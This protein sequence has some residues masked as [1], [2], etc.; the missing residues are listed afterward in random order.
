MKDNRQDIQYF[1]F[2]QYLADGFRVTLEIILPTVI[3]SQFGKMD[4][5][6]MMSTGALCVSI[7]D[8]PGPVEHKQN[9]MLYC[10]L[11]IFLMTLVTGLINTNVLLLGLLVALSSFFFT[12][13][14]VF[15]NR[16]ASLGTA[17]L[18]VMVLRMDK[19]VSPETVLFDSLLVMAGGFWYLLFALLFFKIQPYRPAQRLLGNCLHETARFLRIKAALYDINSNITDEYRKLVT[20]QVVV[21]EKQDEL[22]ELLF[23]NRQLIKEPTDTG[24]LLLVTFA[25]V[26]DLYE[27]IMATWYDYTLLRQKFASTGILREVSEI[28]KNLADETDRIALA[29]QSNSYYKKQYHLLPVLDALKVKIDALEDSNNSNLVLKK[30]LVNLRNLGERTDELMNYFKAGT[31]ARRNLRTDT[32]YAKFV[33]HQVISASVFMSNLSLDSAVFR[34]SLRMMITCITGFIIA[35]L[36]PNAHHSYWILL[37][38]I[39][40]VKPG[41]SLTKQRNL[42]RLFGT[43]AGGIIGVLIIYFIQDR[44]LL[45]GVIIFFMLVTYTFF[46][47]N[48]IVTV[49]FMTPYIIILFY[50]LGIGSVNV[51]EERLLDTGIASVLAFMGSYFLFPHWESVQLESY[52]VKVLEANQ[53]YLQQLAAFFSGNN[54]SHL[55]YR[56]VRKELYVSTA[57]LSA[58]FQRM[59]SEPKSKQRNSQEIYEFVVLNHVLSGNIASLTAS[60]INKEPGQYPK[61]VL[62]PVKK[63]ITILKQSLMLL[64]N[65]FLEEEIV[66]AAIHPLADKADK[67]LTEQLNFIYKVTGDIGKITRQIARKN[68]TAGEQQKILE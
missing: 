58:A 36:L 56:L 66:P 59:L 34:H 47:V 19:I 63:S 55:E 43:I 8:S 57:N 15:G 32:D 6:L 2:S 16:A 13:F 44:T 26:L 33:S 61:E 54:K 21:N 42:E 9:G 24:K 39:V 22:R 29:I 53:N 25:D 64:D 38:I 65:N 14:S 68:Q 35:R 40:I 7:T 48:Y 30:I 10:I 45:F 52:M 62:L 18:L 37:T 3:F 4:L 27:N 41:F 17:V 5:G 60:M 50:L 11:F 31:I 46:R 23:K 49:I 28:I 51:A 67:Q 1:L 20:Q 12:M